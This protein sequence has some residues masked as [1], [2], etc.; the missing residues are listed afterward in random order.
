MDYIYKNNWFNMHIPLSYVFGNCQ[1]VMTKVIT[2]RKS[3]LWLKFV[4]I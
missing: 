1:H 4:C 3:I 2:L